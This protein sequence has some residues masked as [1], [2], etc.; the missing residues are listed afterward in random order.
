MPLFLAA[1]GADLADAQVNIGRF[2]LDRGE[3]LQAARAFE[4]AIQNGNPFSGYH[5]LANL[6]AATSRLPAEKGGKGDM[7][8]IA[9]AFVSSS[10]D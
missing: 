10:Q 2:H 9:V 7:C 4:V 8:G 1:S 3:Q 6:H 5:E